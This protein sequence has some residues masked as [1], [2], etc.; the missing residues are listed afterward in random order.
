MNYSQWLAVSL[1]AITLP[2]I[3]DFVFAL[4]GWNVPLVFIVVFFMIICAVFI[5]EK[6]RSAK[7]S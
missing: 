4:L 7:K 3:I 2:T 5:D 1:H 6:T